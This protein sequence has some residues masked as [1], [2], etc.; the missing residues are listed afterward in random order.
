M[1]NIQSAKKRMRQNIKLRT[2]NRHKKSA[3]RTEEKKV[4]AFVSENKME[5]AEQ[6][7]RRLSSLID[8]AT[9]RNIVHKNAA[10]RKKA[11]LASLFKG[12]ATATAATAPAAAVTTE[13]VETQ[14][15]S[16]EANTE[17]SETSQA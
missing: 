13:E 6:S 9:K 8:R 15:P 14:A 1:P 17:T 16:A 4:R 5:E 12:G 2:Q 7:Y 10:S 11:R 3:I